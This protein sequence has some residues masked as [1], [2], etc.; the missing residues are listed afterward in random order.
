MKKLSFF[1]LLVVLFSSCSTIK[2]V[3]EN[4]FLL[5]KN[6]VYIDSVKNS[7]ENITELLLQRPNAKALG[8]PLSLYFY[9]LG[10]PEA[11]K[12]P[13]KWGEKHSKT[14]SF[15][16]KTFSEKQSISVAKTFIGFNNWFLK[17]GQA[18]IIID[19]K[20]TKR[21]V[22]N[23][24]TY[25][26]TEGYF[27]SKISSKKDTIGN[28]KGAISYTILRGEPSFLD[29]I[30]TKI[31]S[32]V[33]DSLY[34]E[35]KEKSFLKSGDQYKVGNFIKEANRL[36]KLFRNKGV[37]HFN[38]NYI[39]FD[40]DTLKNYQKTAVDINISERVIPFKIQKIKKN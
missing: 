1:F 6:T 24:N 19:D 22:A 16:K 7:N 10:N 14:Y 27:R 4:E 9:N 21:T 15:F 28:R 12:T 18:P 11:P 36:V 25:F 8:M 33:L 23:L 13:S 39:L 30:K 26:Q 29:S 5:T 2:Y 17:S 31:S 35:S 37:Y 32:A 34:K 3:K 40:I 38:E 20:K